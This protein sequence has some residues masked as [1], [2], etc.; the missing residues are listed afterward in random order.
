MHNLKLQDTETFSMQKKWHTDSKT[1]KKKK[2]L[3]VNDC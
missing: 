1:K 3:T 2:I